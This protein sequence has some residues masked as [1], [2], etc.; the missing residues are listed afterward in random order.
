M[1]YRNADGSVA[2]MCGNGIRV[3]ARYLVDEGLAD[4]A[5][6]IPVD[7]RDGVKVLTVDGDLVT[8]DM[9]TPR[10]VGETVVGVGPAQLAGAARRHGQPARGRVR[11]RPSTTR[12]RSSTRRPTTPTPTRTA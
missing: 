7:T 8:V 10:V 1:D 2:E 3:F 9:G 12:A 4:P 5:A 6:P 11:R